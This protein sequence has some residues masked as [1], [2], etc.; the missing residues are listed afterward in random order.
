MPPISRRT[1]LK[2]T[3]ATAGMAIFNPTHITH[4]QLFGLFGGKGQETSPITSNPDFYVTSYDITPEINREKWSLQITGIVKKP[5]AF[6]FADLVKRPQSKMIATLECIGNTVGGYS[7]G[8]AE[9]E[10]VRLKSLLEEA[11][12]DP[13]SVDLVL[14]GADGY[15]DSFPFPRAMEDDVLLATKMN[16]VPLP[17]DHG[18][19][20]RVIVPGIYGMKNVKWLTALELVNY[21]YKGHWQQQSWSDEAL[22]KLSSRIDL[23]GDRETI[24]TP[25]Y[26]MKGIAFNGRHTIQK[27]E[28]S[29][30]GG[31]HWAYGTLLPTLS[32][33]AWTPW[34]YEWTIP[35]QGE[36]T[37]MARATNDAGLTQPVDPKQSPN[38]TLEI[39]AL[40]VIVEP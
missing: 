12:G 16:G 22:V 34:T 25:R 24:T 17:P 28:V 18:F 21:D 5:S 35:K 37:I 9:W 40:N 19:P 11:G 33:Y 3:I 29:T 39:H 32:P 15:S 8:T 2:G 4:A 1:L 10:G 31:K 27:I 14:R 30:D 7:I 20:A 13:K 36:Y 23:P 38:E 6:T 26:T